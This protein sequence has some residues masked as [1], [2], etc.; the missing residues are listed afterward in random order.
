MLHNL[1]LRFT[2][3]KVY[4]Y[5]GIVLVAINP[6][7]QLDIYGD[8]IIKQYLNTTGISNIEP[9][10]YIECKEAYQNMTKL[11]LKFWNFL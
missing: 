9:H 2:K 4:T 6:F 5:C 3:K 1:K 7:E 11:T 10:L 8:K